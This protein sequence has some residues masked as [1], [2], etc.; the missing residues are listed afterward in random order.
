MKM[1]LPHYEKA[2]VPRQKLSNYL[3]SETH[4]VGKAKARYFQSLGYKE[5]NADQLADALLMI[6][7]SEGVTQEV[8]SR[9][10]TKYIIDGEL[11]T[12]IGSRVQLRTV[13]VVEEH[14]ERPRFVTAYPALRADT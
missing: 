10:G 4:A 1:N 9:Y 13:W 6:A 12:P 11:V 2:Y 8:A 7:K 3:L 5:E 14:D